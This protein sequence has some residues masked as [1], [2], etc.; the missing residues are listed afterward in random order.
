MNTSLVLAGTETTGR[1]LQLQIMLLIAI[2]EEAQ[3][4]LISELGAAGGK[5][6]NRR[7]KPIRM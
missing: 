6:L 4:K 3:Q 2:R 5:N 1:A 7:G